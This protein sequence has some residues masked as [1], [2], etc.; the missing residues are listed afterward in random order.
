MGIDIYDILNDVDTNLEE[1]EIIELSDYE[2]KVNSR[3]ILSKIKGRQVRNNMKARNLLKKIGIASAIAVI[4]IAS[5]TTIS[6]ASEGRLFN[7]L[8]TFFN[9]S[10]IISEYDKWTGISKTTIE[11]KVLEN[12]PVKLDGEKLKFIADG[13]EID[14][15]E[16][17]SDKIPYIGEYTDEQN[18]THKF[19]IGGEPIEEGYGYEENLFDSNGKFIG[20]SGYYG[21]KVAGINDG[22]EPEW[23]VVGKNIIGRNEQ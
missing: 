12:P 16:Q 2:N 3:R 6:F 23:L 9:G 13:N 17:I 7:Y 21:S 5:A 4:G 20:A 1:Y 10:G 22:D 11:I 18:V 14:I 19:I 8:Y 15:T